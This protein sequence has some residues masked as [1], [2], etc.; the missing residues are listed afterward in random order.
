[1]IRH[2]YGERRALRGGNGGGVVKRLPSVKD[3][4][5]IGKFQL[6]AYGS[7]SRDG[8]TCPALQPIAVIDAPLRQLARCVNRQRW[9]R[10]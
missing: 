6:D 10:F 2:G 9:L 1:M 4:I 5:A 7:V 8:Q 3:D